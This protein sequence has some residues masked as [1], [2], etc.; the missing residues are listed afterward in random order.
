MEEGVNNLKYEHILVL[1]TNDLLKEESPLP[2]FL[3]KEG[4][5]DLL[6]PPTYTLSGRIRY[7]TMLKAKG[8]ESDAVILVCSGLSGKNAFQIFIG[9]SWAKCRVNLLYKSI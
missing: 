7:K 2:D 1:F 8:L 3:E 5:F 4:S 6:S 9:V